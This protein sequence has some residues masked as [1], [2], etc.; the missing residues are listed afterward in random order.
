MTSRR[1][2]RRWGRCSNLSAHPGAVALTPA[3]QRLDAGGADRPGFLEFEEQGFYQV[4]SA[5]ADESHPTTVAVNLD[6]SESDLSALDP[7]ELVGA[8]TGRAA[9]RMKDTTSPS[10][11]PPEDA[12]RRQSIWWYLLLAGLLLLA[13][14][15]AVSN[16]LSRA[17]GAVPS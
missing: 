17:P 2:G 12:E 11:L 4:R 13:A 5:A 3:G 8:V 7:Q 6:P 16:R 9:P 14:E 15:T 10:A 1:R